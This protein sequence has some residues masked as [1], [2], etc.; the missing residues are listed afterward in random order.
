LH[1]DPQG[2]LLVLD[3]VRLLGPRTRVFA[4]T[5]CW[6]ASGE[7]PPYE[8]LLA[9]ARAGGA[10]TVLDAAQAVGHDGPDLSALAC[11]FAAFSG[12]NIYGPMGTGA[13]VG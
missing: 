2:S 11:D 9:A 10:L 6:N 4:V 13:L 1:P 7:R 12:H 5:A 8:A 3:L